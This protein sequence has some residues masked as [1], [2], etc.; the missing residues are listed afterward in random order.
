MR[1]RLPARFYHLCLRCGWEWISSVR[2]P[3]SCSR[4]RNRYW[5][6]LRGSRPRGRVPGTSIH[7][8]R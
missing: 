1:P 2:A 6:V 4:C 5:N 3:Q 8:P 7:R